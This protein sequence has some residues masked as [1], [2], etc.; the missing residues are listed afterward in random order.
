MELAKSVFEQCKRQN[1]ITNYFKKVDQPDLEGGNNKKQQK[2]ARHARLYVPRIM[3]E[4][5]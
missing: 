4:M 1:R 3:A 2:P 5:M